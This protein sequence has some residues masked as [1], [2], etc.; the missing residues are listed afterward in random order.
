[1]LNAKVATLLGLP[2][3]T[4]AGGLLRLYSVERKSISHPEMYVPRIVLPEGVS[5]PRQRLTLPSVLTGTFSSDTHPPGYYVMMYFWTKLFGTSLF[6]I[7][8]PSVL[9]GTACIPLVFWLGYLLGEPWAGWIAAAAL[10]FSGYHVFWSR[11]ARMFTLECFL[12]LSATILL[13]LI[14]RSARTRPILTMLYVLT[15]ILGASG[16]IFFWTLIGTHV[17]WALIAAL[18]TH[19]PFPGVLKAQALAVTIASPFIAFAAYQRG[20]TLADMSDAFLVFAAE[21]LRM[22]F[23]FASPLSGFFQASPETLPVTRALLLVCCIAAAI[24]GVIRLGRPELDLMRAGDGPLP[25]LWFAAALLACAVIFA[26]VW[27]AYRFISPYPTIATT[28]MLVPLPLL[29]ALIAYLAQRSWPAIL[30]RMGRR[31][32]LSG[33]SGLVIMLAFVP[34]LLLL[35]VS[36]IKPIFNQRGMLLVTPYLFLVIGAGIVSIVRRWRLLATPAVLAFVWMIVLSQGTYSAMNVDPAD[37]R[38]FAGRLTPE[39]RTGDMVFLVRRYN[40]TPVLY[41][42]DANRYHLVASDYGKACERN[43]ESRVWALSL[44]DGEIPEPMLMAL[45]GYRAVQ[46]IEVPYAQA[47]L[48][49]PRRIDVR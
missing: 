26:F 43:P 13:L 34:F 2:L 29:I 3:L 49:E 12:G 15:L 23:I 14:A 11:V 39:M 47:V 42:L 35:S 41:Y 5:E 31:L 24:L 7:R 40:V 1:M 19:A 22:G 48:F 45:A 38:M 6:A 21:F 18:S 30:K 32:P 37:Y 10:A 4:A 25:L 33:T 9:L 46:R 8:L 16:H 28:K 20:T 27:A 36:L 17:L 44:Y